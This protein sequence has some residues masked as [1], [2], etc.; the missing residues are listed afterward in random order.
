MDGFASTKGCGWHWYAFLGSREDR[1]EG[2]RCASE[3]VVRT[4]HRVA[5]SQGRMGGD[6][7]AILNAGY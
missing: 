7:E 6:E 2:V 5:Q 3:H 1:A 4:N